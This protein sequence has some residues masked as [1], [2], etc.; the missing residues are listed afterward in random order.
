M[1]IAC[2]LC[3]LLCVIFFVNVIFWGDKYAKNSD[4]DVK[5]AR[6]SIKYVFIRL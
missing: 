3:A 2:Y 6:S 5:P 4:I 1:T